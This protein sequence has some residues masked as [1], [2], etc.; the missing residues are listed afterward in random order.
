MLRLFAALALSTW[1]V[2]GLLVAP[3]LL[4]QRWRAGRGETG[5]RLVSGWSAWA[6]GLF[7]AVQVMR[8]VSLVT[9]AAPVIPDGWLAELDLQAEGPLREGPMWLFG[10]AGVALLGRL[11]LRRPPGV[12]G[13]PGGPA[14]ASRDAGFELVI[15][16][17]GL[18]FLFQQLA[19]LTASGRPW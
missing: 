11:A 6:L 18:G 16:L 1:L 8:V 10:L 14:G 5:R 15:G 3:A 4:L 13:V 2:S 12:P 9:A 19:V 7:M 17:Y